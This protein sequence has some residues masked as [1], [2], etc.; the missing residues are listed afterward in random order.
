MSPVESHI[1]LDDCRIKVLRAGQGTP[2]VFL[3]GTD[4]S[5]DWQPYLD[6]LARRFDVIVPEHPGFGGQ[7][8]P[9]WLDRIADYSNFYLDLLDR[10]DLKDVHL[11]G[12]GMG[13]WIAAELATRDTRCIAS[14]TLVDAQGLWLDGVPTLD[15]F[16]CTE[17]QAIADLFHDPKLAEAETARRLTPESEDMRLNNQVVIA[18]TTWQPRGYD[19][20]LRKWLH[21]IDVPTLIVWGAED[22]LLPQAYAQEWGKIIPGAQVEIIAACGHVPPI[23]KPA[24]F[25]R[26]IS[27]FAAAERAAA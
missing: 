18:Q 3:R 8:K 5:D 6:E 15:T 27:D 24:E 22:R 12:H 21:R 23:E 14:L 11:V 13:G 2:L 19:P 17:E 16:L 25:V 10:L 20:H 1:D 9:K 4:A 7:P 26:L